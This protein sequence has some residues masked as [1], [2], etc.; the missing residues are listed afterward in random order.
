MTRHLSLWALCALIAVLAVPSAADLDEQA[1]EV[2]EDCSVDSDL[3]TPHKPWG[4]GHVGGPLRALFFVYT[5]PYDGGWEDPSTR[6][7][8]VVE[9]T[10][11]FDVQADAVFFCGSDAKR[12][13]AFHGRAVGAERAERLLQT[14][15]DLYVIG[16][17]PM[18]KLPA[19]IQYLILKHV[20][21][22]AGLIS[23]GPSPNEYMTPARRLDPTPASLTDGLP[24]VGD[25][26]AGNVVS[27]YELREGRGVWLNWPAH[28]LTPRPS[29]T[30]R[31]LAE[32]DYLMMLLGRAVLWAAGREGDVAVETAPVEVAREAAPVTAEVGLANRADRPMQATLAVELCRADDGLATSLGETAVTIPPGETVRVPISIPP[33]RAGDY[34]VDAMLTS[35]R[36]VEAFGAGNLLVTSEAGVEEVTREGTF[37]ER[38]EVMRGAVTLRGAPPEGSV[39]QV[40]F[41]DSYDR[42]LRRE[43][44]PVVADQAQYPF[45]HE[46][47]E[48]CTILMRVEAAL[49]VDGEEVEMKQASFT[50]PN[51]RQG[52]F[53]F[54]MWDTPHDVLGY[55]AWRKLQEA[56]MNVSLIGAFTE[57]AQPPALRACDG[58]VAPYSTRI[59]DPKDEDG[60]MEPVCWNDEPAVDEYV[61]RIVNNQKHLREQGVFV[62]SLG[63]EGV[64]RGC[65]VHPACIAA[66]RRYLADQYGTIEALNESWGEQ[67][68]SFEEVDLLDRTDNMETGALA[69]S[70]PRWYDRQA[71]AR[72]NLMQ[73]VRRFV[74]AYKELDP[75][76]LTGFEGTGGFGDDYDAML[77]MME[78]YGPYPSI[79]DDIVRSAAPREMVRSNWMG[80]SK[81]GDALSDAGWRML[82]KGMDT[83]WFW[84]WSGIGAWRGYLR[85]TLDFWPATEDLAEEMRPIHRGLGDL[86]INS[87]MTHNGIAIF[88]SVPSALGHRFEGGRE[89]IATQATHEAWV[90]LTYDL[91]LDL[92]YVTSAMVTDGALEGDEFKVLLLPSAPAISPAEAQAIRDFVEAGGTVIADVRPA[93]YDGHCKPVMPGA[94]DDLFGIERTGRGKAHTDT[95]NLRASLDAHGVNLSLPEARVDEDVRAGAADALAQVGETPVMLVNSVGQGRAIL[96]NF[97][98][99]TPGD[100]APET[101]RVRELLRF[102]YD[103][104]GV[105]AGVRVSAPRGG[106]LPRTETRVWR[107][108]DATVFGLWRQMEMKWFGPTE[109]TIGGPPVPA[110]IELPAP[111]HVYDLRAGRYLGQVSR[112]DTRLRW[113]RASFFTALPYEIPAPT[114]AVSEETP[115]PGEAVTVTL[116]LPVPRGS[117]A[118]HALWVEVTDPEGDKPFWGQQVVLLQEGRPARVRFA[119]AHNDV[120]GRWLVT[121]TEL[122]SGR[123]AQA[124]WTR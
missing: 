19:K 88:Y 44:F 61:Q 12:V 34:F 47:D 13:W 85:P 46:A 11:R 51:R 102:L 9:L 106:P 14:P 4:R 68:A 29:F 80:Y 33:L 35:R 121:A 113:G 76:A 54:V 110:R 37:A 22:G 42:I 79:G 103:A 91:G 3:V 107:N 112:I 18:D 31:A 15:Y 96:L 75:H 124:G 78:F 108:G 87:E 84:M 60:F 23:C 89:F 99:S 1:R 57:R 123:S 92:R 27:A 24:Q 30:W 49:V 81:T 105:E 62:Y 71:F 17:F 7:R 97:Q 114:V 5:G 119:V 70:F 20:V 38:G 104:A 40:R 6:V 43:E 101:A 55:W 90:Q 83:N 28:A 72:Y 21:E 111:Q 64:T 8:E 117:T 73:F 116:R 109:G 59:L 41:R 2:E 52:Q 120:P 66:Y 94:L 16:G 98:F 58:S 45:E 36:G 100:H 67:Y 53:N 25:W 115:A 95:V 93:L 32:Y 48:L 10:Q 39:L 122:F 56:G 50:V 69:T 118:R 65:C 26:R 86:V 74:D 77:S 63:D 82:M